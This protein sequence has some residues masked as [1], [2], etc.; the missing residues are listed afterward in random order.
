MESML[1]PS[2]RRCY[3][4]MCQGYEQRDLPALLGVSRQAV[5]RMVA[6]IRRKY[7]NIEKSA[8]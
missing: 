6:S 3:D 5:S 2:E 1:S 7:L 8:N 4:L